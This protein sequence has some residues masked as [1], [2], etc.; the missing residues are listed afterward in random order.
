MSGVVSDRLEP[1]WDVLA[2]VLSHLETS[3]SCGILKDPAALAGL[4]KSYESIAG[5]DRA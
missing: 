3:G 4:E 1:L 2:R 5:L